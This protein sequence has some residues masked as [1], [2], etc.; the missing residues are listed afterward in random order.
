MS[1]RTVPLPTAAE[2]WLFLAA[3]LA[4][5]SLVWSGLFLL[6]PSD[7]PWAGGSSMGPGVI[8]LFLGGGAIPSLLGFAFA[9]RRGSWPSVRA[10]LA[11]ALP[12]GGDPLT[13]LVAMA[14]AIAAALA[15]R[16]AGSQLGA[17]PPPLDLSAIPQVA[18]MALAAALMEEFGWRGTALPALAR[19]IGLPLAGLVVG[20]V[21]AV[22]HTVGALWSVAPFFGPWFAA[23]YLTG[24]I[25][26]MAGAGMTLAVIQDFA[27]GGL[28]PVIAFHLAF[29][30][31]AS[32]ATPSAG[33]PAGAV[34][35]AACLAV[36]HIAIGIAALAWRRAR[37]AATTVAV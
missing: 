33:D 34:K 23:Y 20:V 19:R 25:G 12:R 4:L 3:A 6:D 32:L 21:W 31:S 1:A 35:I 22:W 13:A 37:N 36:A 18:A 2:G 17:N 30:A 29:S 27:R 7:N 15:A 11:R 9:Y 8:V 26:V 28:F 16:A 10:L 24:I 5:S 14:I